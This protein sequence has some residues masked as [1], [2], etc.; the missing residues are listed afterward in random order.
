MDTSYNE[1]M[2]VNY[3]PAC[4]HALCAVPKPDGNN[5][6]M[7]YCSQPIGSSVNFHCPSFMESLHFQS[8]DEKIS[9]FLCFWAGWGIKVLLF[10]HNHV[11][12]FPCTGINDN[13]F[14]IDCSEHNNAVT[15]TM[16]TLLCN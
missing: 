13:H 2:V 14:V 8:V 5:R 15:T 12:T 4:V 7:T 10:T 3:D 16:V 1:K 11:V 9:S 6:P